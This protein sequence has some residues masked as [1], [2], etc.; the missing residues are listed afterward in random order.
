MK[1]RTTTVT[2]AADREAVFAFLADLNNLPRWAPA[3]CRELRRDGHH[4]R[5]TTPGGQDYF[6]LLTDNRTGVLDLFVGQRPDEMALL[7][8]RVLRQPE[9]TA[10]TCTFFRPRGWSEEVSDRYA[11]ALRAGLY[12]LVAIFGGEVAG[13]RSERSWFYPSVVTGRFFETWDFYTGHLGFRTVCENDVYVHLE[14]PGGAQLGVLREEIDGLP[15]EL[16][17]AT[18]GRGFWLNIE[19]ADAD[20]EHA[21]L[22]QA[23]LEIVEPVE[24]KP[25]GNRQF[26]VRDPNGVLIAIAHRIPAG[27]ETLACLPAAS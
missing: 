8:L 13:D 19:V 20:A 10:V 26:V 21:R 3:L 17:G 18:S 12:G 1:T 16:T 5:G 25:W 2:V 27:A 7:P 15:A 9:G 6:A 4:W 23:G 24:D 11:D 22:A 14:H